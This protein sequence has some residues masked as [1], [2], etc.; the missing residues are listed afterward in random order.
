[1]GVYLDSEIGRLKRV[2]VHTPGAEIER[3]TPESARR[4]LYHDII[5]ISVVS[6]EHEKLKR[7][8]SLVSEVYE[9]QELV[10]DVLHRYPEAR[11]ALVDSVA[12]SARSAELLR[13]SAV[14]LA[15]A[16]VC[17]LPAR[18]ASLSDYLSDRLH[19]VPPLPNLYF[20]RDG[21]M[22]FRDHV[23]VGAMAYHVRLNESLLLKTVFSHSRTLRSGGLLFDGVREG[24]GNVRLEGGDF[25][26]VD[27]NTLIL[28]VSE[29]SSPE[30]LDRL[31]RNLVE[32]FLEPFRLFV[33]LLPHEPSTIHLDMVFTL[34]DRDVALVYEPY[35]LGSKRLRVVRMDI[36]PERDPELREVSGLIEG[37]TEV[38]V[39]VEPLLCGGSSAVYQQRE[40]WMSGTNVFAFGPGKA[41]GYDCNAETA[42]A[43]S[44]A[45]FAVRPVDGF[46]SGTES[47]DDYERLLVVTPGVEL[48]RGGGGARCMTLPVERE[49]LA[50]Q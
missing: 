49:P 7:F 47:P 38:G 27:R 6:H 36:A 12:P 1:M 32:T 11:A 2:I 18:K 24:C 29:R 5:P 9:L 20:M 30:A 42:K 41:I 40:Q 39:R 44:Q 50:E 22:V 21:A 26:V 17:G 28:G 15:D 48:A 16:L 31:G 35:I 10:A 3:M 33:V 37:L 19:D 14:E 45:G 34:V 46:L 13:F 8:L 4:L 25:M 23:I 43:F